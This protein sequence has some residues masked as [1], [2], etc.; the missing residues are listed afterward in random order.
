MV[1]RQNN[2]RNVRLGN[3]LHRQ[4]IK[5]GICLVSRGGGWSS[6]DYGYIK[7]TSGSNSVE[8]PAVGWRDNNSYGTLYS[9]GQAGEY[10]S[11]VAGG[12]NNAYHLQFNGTG[13]GVYAD[14]NRRLG[15]SVRC[16][17]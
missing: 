11:S 15:N 12:L 13:I 8:F 9:A 16:V 1:E 7:F 14:F 2:T 17:R 5:N 10:W 3:L 4:A 6:S